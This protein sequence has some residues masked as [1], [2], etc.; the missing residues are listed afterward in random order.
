MGGIS[1]SVGLVSGIN[2][3]Q[4]IEQLIAIE[5][6]P[7]AQLQSRIEKNNSVRVAYTEL[8]TRL[9][10]LRVNMQSLK[11][12][13]NFR[14]GV[15]NS[16]NSNVLTAT[17]GAGV[18]P[19]TYQFQVARLVSA[20]QSV[21]G[22]FGD[23][24]SKVGAGTVTVELGGG[25]LKTTTDLS[26]LNGGAGVRRGVF[27][28]TDRSGASS[29]VD[30]SN[31]ITL[32][33]VAK[34][35]NTS[36][37]VSVKAEIGKNGLLLMDL[38]GS[39]STGLKI[40]DL[41]GGSAAADLGIAGTFGASSVTGATINRIGRDTALNT[42]NDGR[43]IRT[44]VNTGQPD[45]VLQLRNGTTRNIEISSA[46]TVGDLI[47]SF[48][49][50]TGGAARLEVGSNGRGFRVV[51]QTGGSGTLS[52]SNSFNS[53]A[54]SDLGLQFGVGS[55]TL[56]GS[57][58]RATLGTVLT[59]SLNGGNGLELGGIVVNVGGTE[60]PVDLSG[61]TT[62]QEI[63]EKIN[64]TGLATATL[65]DSGNGIQV[66]SN[67]GEPLTISSDDGTE[68]AEALGIAGTFANGQ[69]TGANLQRQYINENTLM[70]TYNGGKGV[71]RGKFRVTDATGKSAE[72]DLTQGN[73]T[74]LRD[75]I[76]EINS[77]G[78]KINARVNDRG[79]GLLLESTATTT[80][81]IRVEDTTGTAAAALQIA[82][83]SS[84]GKIDGSF[85]KT[86]T[87]TAADTVATFRDKLNALN[88]GVAASVINDGSAA[89]PTRLSLT[90]KDAGRSA[91]FIF[92]A[93]T[94]QLGASNL[95]EAQDAAVFLGTS[96]ASQPVLLTS[97]KNQIAGAISGVTIDLVSAS[98]SPV[99]VS[100]TRNGKA[101]GE[102]IAAFVE[103]FNSLAEKLK[104]LTKFDPTT[105][106]RGLLL[107]D[108]AIRTVEQ[109]LYSSLSKVVEGVG[110]FRTLG[111][112][113]VKQVRGGGLEFDESKFT[114]AY[115]EDPAAAEAL[116][117]TFEQVVTTTTQ[118]GTNKNTTVVRTINGTEAV[119]KKT[120]SAAG[121]TTTVEVKNEPRGFAQ[122]I[123]AAINRLIDVSEGV[124]PLNN[125][126]IDRV[127]QGLTGRI[128]QLD[129][130]IGNKRS[131]LER[132][133]A[134]MESV[135]ANLQNQGSAIN[136]I[137]TISF[138]SNKK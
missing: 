23:S 5:S 48:N 44:A 116:F 17:A 42:L 70:S 65:K 98:E 115:N 45:L 40:Q 34:K 86:L 125:R 83:S 111:E 53:G 30:I 97:T 4:I 51:D 123:E 85:E 92:D 131:R 68:S 76:S 55:D 102:Q 1:S 7:K 60:E 32:E 110:R 69:V 94:T 11:R 136:N 6:R 64:A 14:T 100:V 61:A 87:V 39:T 47:D 107:G 129:T 91:R 128:T 122:L 114:A 59:R 36:L 33:D 10:S 43:G 127:N 2:T 56:D 121:V 108:S 104:E 73:E 109:N 75:V 35:I 106:E 38:T 71:P 8:Q 19:G 99:S 20:Q 26:S 80:G 22:G 103:N 133:F 119:G 88:F 89:N 9:T 66:R 118:S 113:G 105:G 27:R 21:T 57:A 41:S 124:I 117:T 3:G 15:A 134:Q 79:D 24:S 63:L 81:V 72:V 120:S 112:V 78:L 101:A 77:R 138:S 130:L 25:E 137:Q 49:S 13:T 82:G 46:R 18:T 90:A 31:A 74:T 95:V 29:T 54:A 96:S 58:L 67:T 37:G 62:V 84:T 135:L 52:V 132:Q 126:T 28:I 50:Q 12:S 93:G 16:S